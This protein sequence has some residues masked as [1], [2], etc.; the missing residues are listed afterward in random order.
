MRFLLLQNPLLT[1]GVSNL[2]VAQTK[3]T[4]VSFLVKVSLKT[5]INDTRHVPGTSIMTPV[6]LF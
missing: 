3:N 2:N 5:H 1:T 6:G 4:N